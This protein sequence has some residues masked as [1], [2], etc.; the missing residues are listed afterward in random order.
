MKNTMKCTFNIQ[1]DL[2][3][4]LK[5]LTQ[6][7]EIPSVNRGI[8]EAVELY[9]R[10]KKKKHYEVLMEE[11]VHD[12]KFMQRLKDVDS[13]YSSIDQVVPGKW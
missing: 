5:S 9:L 2:L 7:K 10:A 1:A 6:Q 3:S 4:E 13:D 11:A 8:N 12:S